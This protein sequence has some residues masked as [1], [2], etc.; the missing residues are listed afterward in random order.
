V[1]LTT[2]GDLLKRIRRQ[3]Q[4]FQRDPKK[5]CRR[6]GGFSLIVLAAE[7]FAPF[8]PVF[9]WQAAVEQ[10]QAGGQVNRT[11]PAVDMPGQ[12]G[13]VPSSINAGFIPTSNEANRPGSGLGRR[14]SA[15][16]LI[17]SAQKIS[18][19][20]VSAMVA[21]VNKRSRTGSARSHC[22]RSQ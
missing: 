7:M 6:V 21:C 4:P 10:L 1:D 18:I 2:F 13:T 17:G 16:S 12:L 11:V 19:L 20:Q 9:G 15:G 5:H 14:F 3:G 8:A 22:S